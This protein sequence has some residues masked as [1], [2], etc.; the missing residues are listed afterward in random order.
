M[1]IETDFQ[2]SNLLASANDNEGVLKYL[3]RIF[4]KGSSTHIYSSQPLKIVN[5][6]MKVK[7]T[8]PVI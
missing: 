1:S 2:T 6:L 8:K 7:K 3:S 5:Y 4:K